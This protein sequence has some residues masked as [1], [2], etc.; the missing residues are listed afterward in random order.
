M[1]CSFKIYFFKEKLSFKRA[2]IKKEP[3]QW[4]F[5]CIYAIDSK[6]FLDLQLMG[7][8]VLLIRVA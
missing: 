2:V 4:F 5:F 6:Y 3:L 1:I 7:D 8:H